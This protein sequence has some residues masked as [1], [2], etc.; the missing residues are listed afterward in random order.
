VHPPL[1]DRGADI[2]KARGELEAHGC[3]VVSDPWRDPGE[4]PRAGGTIAELVPVGRY[5]R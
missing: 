4:V 1:R 2:A 3:D 5:K